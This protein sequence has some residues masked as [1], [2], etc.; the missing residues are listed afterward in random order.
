MRLKN[1]L[2]MTHIGPIW[3]PYGS[4]S[5]IFSVWKNISMIPTTVPFSLQ[6]IQTVSICFRCIKEV[7][8]NQYYWVNINYMSNYRRL[9]SSNLKTT[10]HMGPIW[11][12]YGPHMGRSLSEEKIQFLSYNFENMGWKTCA[13]EF[14]RELNMLYLNPKYYTAYQSQFW[15]P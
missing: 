10:T 9:L 1:V 3:D 13:N 8:N 12:P 11:V 2:V 6:S 4:S 14:W 7:T 5:W 15:N